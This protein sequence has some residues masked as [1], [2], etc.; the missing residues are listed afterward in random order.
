MT[1]LEA[2][3]LLAQLVTSSWAQAGVGLWQWVAASE[4]A[5][6]EDLMDGVVVEEEWALAL[7]RRDGDWQRP[8][9]TGQEA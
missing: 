4:A 5:K 9:R 2:V 7:E 1:N 3:A 8:G 6:A